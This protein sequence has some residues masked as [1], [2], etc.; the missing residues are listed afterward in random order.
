L[1]C[2]KRNWK[3]EKRLGRRRDPR[4]DLST[5]RREPI[6]LEPPQI[7]WRKETGLSAGTGLKGAVAKRLNYQEQ[8]EL[9]NEQIH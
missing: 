4:E 3:S 2:A 8:K 7:L 6:A 9:S 5:I 1:Y